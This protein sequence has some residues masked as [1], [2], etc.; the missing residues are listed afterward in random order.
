MSDPRPENDS[1]QHEV[2]EGLSVEWV[3]APFWR[4]AFAYFVDTAVLSVAVYLLLIACVFVF[5][6]M[7]VGV[8]HFQKN[9]T[10]Y[11]RYM[12]ESAGMIVA[13]ILVL[14]VILFFTSVFH[15]YFIYFEYK[16]G[17]TPGKR[18][19][20]L[21]VLSLSG[22]RLSKKQC[23]VREMFKYLD[24]LFVPALIS[25]ALTKRRQRLGDLAAATMVTWSDSAEKSL[26]YM[27]LKQEVYQ[28]YLE[29]FKPRA[30][31]S[32]ERRR[33]LELC[34]PKFVLGK[35][36]AESELKVGQLVDFVDGLIQGKG[37]N[38]STELKLRFIAEYSFQGSQDKAT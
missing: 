11:F 24:M 8:V 7:A 29:A 19:F 35:E 4:R 38:L 16:R 30:L 31:L 32:E 13:V 28:Y 34:Y 1:V 22:S 10:E 26:S 36:V 25:W 14:L 5:S 23:L 18:L 6:L 12:T 27:Y 2:F 3:P 17:A 20:G 33:I 21:K 9:F 15:V 37:A